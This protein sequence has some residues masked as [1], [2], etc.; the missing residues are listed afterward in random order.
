MIPH[1]FTT[2]LWVTSSATVYFRCYDHVC[3]D[4]IREGSEQCDN[5]NTTGCVNCI[6]DPSYSCVAVTPTSGPC[7]CWLPSFVYDLTS[8]QCIINCS[9]I[10]NGIQNKPGTT[11]ECLCMPQYFFDPSIYQCVVNCSSVAGTLGSLNGVCICPE[12]YYFNQPLL[13]C[14]INCS[15]ITNTVGYDLAMNYDRCKCKHQFSFNLVDL[16]CVINCT[17]VGGTS[18][19][20][21][22][23]DQC[24]CA[25]G[26]QWT[27]DG[28]KSVCGD[29]VQSADQQCDDGNLDN[30]DTCTD[31][32]TPLQK[33][34]LKTVEIGLIVGLCIAILVAIII[35][36]IAICKYRQFTR[37]QIPSDSYTTDSIKIVK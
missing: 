24:T 18:P 5:G 6:A 27:S 28:C 25:S 30:N 16:T 34:G 3:G 23:L 17:L 14:V 11:D 8:H 32:C 37:L 4:G 22:T 9:A 36:L 1:S 35:C 19:V 7:N 21:G 2:G 20:A 33:S 29:G 13:S 10:S 15:A 12:K 26:Y 31:K